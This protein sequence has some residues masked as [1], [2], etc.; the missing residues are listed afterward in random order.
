M[1]HFPPWKRTKKVVFFLVVWWSCVHVS[2]HGSVHI[3]THHSWLRRVFLSGHDRTAFQSGKTLSQ[4]LHVGPGR[5]FGIC[6]QVVPDQMSSSC[7]GHVWCSLCLDENVRSE[8]MRCINWILSNAFWVFFVCETT[9]GFATVSNT[10]LCLCG[11]DNKFDL[12]DLKTLHAS[13]CHIDDEHSVG[14]FTNYKRIVCPTGATILWVSIFR[15]T[16]LGSK[17]HAVPY[18]LAAQQWRLSP[19]FHAFHCSSGKVAGKKTDYRNI[20]ICD[21]VC[22]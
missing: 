13:G 21:Y 11:T 1:N 16:Y 9:C 6:Q 18:Q 2:I 12:I 22:Y 17:P 14:N 4:K 19:H 3:I 5:H 7:D 8:I 20:C 10:C 15:F